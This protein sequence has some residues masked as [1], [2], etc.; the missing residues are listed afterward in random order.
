MTPSDTT[1]VIASRNRA[2]ELAVVVGRLLDTTACPIV[3]VDN[4]SEDHSVALMRRLA[5]RSAHRLRLIELDTNRGAVGRNFGVAACTT[6]ADIPSSGA[7][8]TEAWAEA[9][10]LENQRLFRA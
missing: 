3:V 1:F 10:A 9:H 6:P 4:A 7:P 5:T 8:Q 2:T